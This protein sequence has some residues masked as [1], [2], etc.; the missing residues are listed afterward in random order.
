ML[1][2]LPGQDKIH[3]Y[4]RKNRFSQAWG[5]RAYHAG[6]IIWSLDHE[7]RSTDLE[8]YLPSSDMN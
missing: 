4:A 7:K 1:R 5:A 2:F 3:I 8:T 6:L